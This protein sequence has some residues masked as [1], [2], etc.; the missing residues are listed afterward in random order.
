MQQQMSRMT[1]IH[2]LEEGKRD[3]ANGD[4]YNLV[5]V[6]YSVVLFLLGI[7][8]T[9]KSLPNRKLVVLIAI[10]GFIIGTVYMLT[11]PMPTGFDFTSFFSL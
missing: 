11:I 7:A 6:F 4:S 5:T 2:A 9:F 3:N 8:G 10:I 1:V